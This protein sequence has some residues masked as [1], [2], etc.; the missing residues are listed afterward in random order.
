MATI[1][2]HQR[3]RSQDHYRE[4]RY[5]DSSVASSDEDEVHST[6]L[7]DTPDS[8][9]KL[10]NGEDSY[11]NPLGLSRTNSIM[12]LSR[13]SF[14]TQL[15]Q[16]TSLNLP[17]ATSLSS[18]VTAIPTASTAAKVLSNAAVQI[19][20]WIQKAAE[21]LG[22][23][24]A[25][26]DVEWAAAGGREGLGEVDAAVGKFEGLVQVYVDAIEELQQREDISKVAQDELKVVVD[27]MDIVIEAWENVRKLLR[28]VKEQV[29]LAMEWE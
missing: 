22:G 14:A 18:S 1:T 12:T 21:V 2:Q 3:E 27:T 19:Q 15:A 4:T 24:D 10:S 13:A 16:L 7:P 5:N 17:D 6:P 28:G 26:D 23:L 25:E 11:F 20:R 9:I 8:T 29:E